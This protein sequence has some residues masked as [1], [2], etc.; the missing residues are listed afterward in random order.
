MTVKGVMHWAQNE[1]EHVGYLVGVRD[2]DIQYAYAQSTVNGMLHLRDAL[3]ELV[4]DPNYVTHKEE[5][6]RTHD[7]VVRVVK[8]LIKDFNVNFEDIKTFNTRHV[9][10]N[11][12]Y[13]NENKPKTNGGRRRTRKHRRGGQRA[14][15]STCPPGQTGVNFKNWGGACGPYNSTYKLMSGTTN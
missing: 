5:L 15:A 1:L 9:L 8:H 2:P 4:N 12:S 10:G 6:Q 11:L 3:L 14:N 13:L 7:K